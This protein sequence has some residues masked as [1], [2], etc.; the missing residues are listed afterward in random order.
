M[1]YKRI[2]SIYLLEVFSNESKIWRFLLLLGFP[3]FSASSKKYF[4]FVRKNYSLGNLTQEYISRLNFERF[5][6][7]IYRKYIVNQQKEAAERLK[8]ISKHK[9]L[10]INDLLKNAK[11]SRLVEYTLLKYSLYLPLKT[12][13]SIKAQ[14]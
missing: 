4:D 1:F 10:F 8:T 6:H 7:S 9:K 13:L 3:C 11:K 5:E 14:K 2:K 12:M